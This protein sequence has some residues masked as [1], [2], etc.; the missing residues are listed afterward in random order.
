MAQEILEL[1]SGK[2]EKEQNDILFEVRNAI[3]ESRMKQANTLE[4]EV[5][6]IRDTL[7]QV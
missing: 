6:R 7:N 1:L 2:T 4:R 5:K 3:K